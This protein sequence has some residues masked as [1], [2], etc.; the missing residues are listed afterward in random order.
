M[1]VLITGPSGFLGRNVADILLKLGV[2]VYGFDKRV[3]ARLSEKGVHYIEGDL[4][5]FNK[6]TKA[7]K[8][9]DVVVHLAAATTAIDKKTNY[10]VNVLG[11]KNVVNA[12]KNAGVK[13]IIFISSVNATLRQKSFYGKSKQIA[14]KVV[15]LSNLDYVIFRPELIYGKGDRGLSKT[16]SLIKSLPVIPILGDGYAEMQ[17]I[18]VEDLAKIIVI[19]TMKKVKKGIYF[20]GGPDCFSFNGYINRICKELNIKKRKI[21]VPYLLIISIA[22]ILSKLMNKPPVSLEQVYSMNQHKS[23]SIKSLKNNFEIKLTRF[24]DGLRETLS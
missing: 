6:I 22:K 10:V 13:K 1:K 12:C 24:E 3:N 11:T 17:P 19:A 16:I 5:D 7:V 2:T 20:A 4:T 21:H 14:E 8:G 15:A 18:Y 23:G 9:M